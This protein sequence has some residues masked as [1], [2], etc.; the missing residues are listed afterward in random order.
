[1]W[2]LYGTYDYIAPQ[3]FR[4]SST[5][6]NIGTTG[7]WWLSRAVVLQGTALG[8]V[9]YGAAGTIRGSG[10]RDYHYGATPQG[11]LELRLILG[12]MAMLNVTAHEYY[13]S[14]VGSTE[15]RGSENI[16]RGTASV[17]MRVYDRHAIALRYIAS[18]RDAHYPDL[19]D[20]HQTV[21]TVTVGYTYLGSTGFGAVDW[22]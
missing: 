1:V 22:R 4:V 12:D 10:E 2:G 8:G 14:G 20:S 9:G 3:V 15:N 5:A 13:I 7:Q 21:T 19:A 16:A 17:T 11:L 6:L 18:Y